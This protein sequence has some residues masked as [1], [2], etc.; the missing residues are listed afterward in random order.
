ML[1]FNSTTVRQQEV[2]LLISVMTILGFEIWLDDMTKAYIQGAERIIRNV[3]IRGKQQFQIEDHELLEILRP[4]YELGDVGDYRHD[5][6][7]RQLKR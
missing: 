4:L 7:L 3:Y 6:F 2:R 5:N 1:F